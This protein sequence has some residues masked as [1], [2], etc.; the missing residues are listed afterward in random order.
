MNLATGIVLAVIAVILVAII[1]NSIINRKKGK[2]SCS[3]G[4]SCEAC[5]LNCSAK[6]NQNK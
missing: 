6:I 2:H 1:V 3:C 5:G 4:G